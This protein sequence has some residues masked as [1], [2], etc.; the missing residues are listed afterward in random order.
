MK[1]N[2]SYS[3][4]DI[5]YENGDYW[6][7]QTDSGYEVYRIGVTCSTRCVIIGFKGKEG[8]EHAIY[9]CNKRNNEKNKVTV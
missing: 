7:L 4:R 9:E 8:L 5:A 6:V 2:T 3:T 1:T